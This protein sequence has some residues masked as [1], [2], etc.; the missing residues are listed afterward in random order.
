MSSVLGYKASNPY[1]L[2]WITRDGFGIIKNPTPQWIARSL[3]IR[4][5]LST[6]PSY[7]TVTF[8]CPI[9]CSTVVQWWT[10]ICKLRLNWATSAPKNQVSIDNNFITY[11]D[12]TPPLRLNGKVTKMQKKKREYGEATAWVLSL[13]LSILVI[14]RVLVWA[15]QK[16]ST[17]R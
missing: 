11:R 8:L 2:A 9:F 1:P 10:T 13:P 5:Q 15:K 17:K 16:V 6:A 4:L 7:N 14:W 3:S 12:G